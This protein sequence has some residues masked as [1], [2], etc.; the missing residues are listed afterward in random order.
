MSQQQILAAMRQLHAEGKAITTAT[1]KARL[2]SAVALS[3]LLPLV[4]RY[5]AHPE[6]LVHPEKL[7]L[8][9]NASALLEPAHPA[10]ERVNDLAE[11]KHRLHSLE[12]TVIEQASQLARLEALLPSELSQ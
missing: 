12:Q 7:V 6:S 1:V 9:D 3:E 10:G 8:P 11:L 5:K 2:S 4:A